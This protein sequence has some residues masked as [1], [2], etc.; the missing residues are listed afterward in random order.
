MYKSFSVLAMLALLAGC[1]HTPQKNTSETA[2]TYQAV[3][4]VTPGV[5]G[6]RCFVQSGVASYT[7]DST[8]GTVMVR[9]APDPLDISCFKGAHMVGHTTVRPTVAPREAKVAHGQVCESCLYPKSV[10]VVMALRASSVEKKNV[11]MW[12]E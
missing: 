5:T 1:G 3:G 11:R 6:A 10:R 12:A 9:A 2:T 4:V 8:P 7:L